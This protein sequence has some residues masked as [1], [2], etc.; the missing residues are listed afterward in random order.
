MQGETGGGTVREMRDGERRGRPAVFVQEDDVGEAACVG[1]AHERG[2][3]VRAAV[4]P[5][6]R[7]EE[8]ADFFGE[9][10]EPRGGAAA[11]GDQWAGV[12]DA[13]EV[14]VFIV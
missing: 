8:E 2:E 7:G 6:G 4:Q 11:G 14:R 5:D 13:G 12:D 9:G 10:A 3:D 1:A